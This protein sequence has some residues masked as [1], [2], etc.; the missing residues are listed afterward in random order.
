MRNR[1]CQ[2]VPETIYTISM[3]SLPFAACTQVGQ[4][5]YQQKLYVYDLP[6]NVLL[7]SFGAHYLTRC[8]K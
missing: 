5:I 7:D 1:Q 2:G 4:E 6:H 3:D 8:Y